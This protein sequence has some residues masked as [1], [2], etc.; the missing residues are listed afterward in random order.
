M[1]VYQTSLVEG[2]RFKWF[3]LRYSWLDVVDNSAR[4]IVYNIH[5]ARQI[6]DYYER[7]LE[8]TIE[9]W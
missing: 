2:D 3:C 5:I 6:G 7:S 1:R 9:F 8:C 4:S